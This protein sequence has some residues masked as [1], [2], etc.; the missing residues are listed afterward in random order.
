MLFT[1]LI[2]LFS[3]ISL[4]YVYQGQPTIALDKGSTT[5][6]HT[7]AQYDQVGVVTLCDYLGSSWRYEGVLCKADDPKLTSWTFRQ[8]G[9]TSRTVVCMSHLALV[10]VGMHGMTL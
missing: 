8:Q 2:L 5:P 3:V 10:S 6:L 9:S 4:L 7:V 1:T